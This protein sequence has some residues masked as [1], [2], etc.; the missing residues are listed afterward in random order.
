MQMPLQH[1]SITE[2]AVSETFR[3]FICLGMQYHPLH[4]QVTSYN[5]DAY[6]SDSVKSGCVVLAWRMHKILGHKK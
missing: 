5:I 6:K 3:S 1:D 2:V 4:L